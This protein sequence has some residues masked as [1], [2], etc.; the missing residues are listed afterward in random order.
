MPIVVQEKTLPRIVIAR[1]ATSAI[2]EEKVFSVFAF[3][4]VHPRSSAASSQ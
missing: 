3:I 2:G 1:E 4:C